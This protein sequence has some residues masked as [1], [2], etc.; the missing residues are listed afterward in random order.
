MGNEHSTPL[1]PVI[2]SWINRPLEGSFG[3]VP[4]RNSLRLLRPSPSQSPSRSFVPVPGRSGLMPKCS[5]A[6][7]SWIPSPS[8]SSDWKSVA[9]I[10][11]PVLSMRNEASRLLVSRRWPKTMLEKADA[12]LPYWIKRNFVNWKESH[13][14]LIDI[15]RFPASETL[16]GNNQGTVLRE[17]RRTCD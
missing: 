3:S 14:G 7:A 10:A 15:P 9:M 11:V 5:M 1:C 2:S 12:M 17:A 4:S 16:A 13:P 8:K 6:Q